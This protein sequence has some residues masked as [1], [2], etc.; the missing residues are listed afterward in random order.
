ME[1]AP[2]IAL[3]YCGLIFIL[4]LAIILLVLAIISMIKGKRENK[5]NYKLRGRIFLILSLICFTPVLLVVGLCLYY[6]LGNM[7]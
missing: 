4:I 1:N 6:C 5:K 7:L 3:F 2:T